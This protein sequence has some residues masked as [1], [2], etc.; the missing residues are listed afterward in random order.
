[1]PLNHRRTPSSQ[2]LQSE[3]RKSPDLAA[4]RLSFSWLELHRALSA[5]QY[6]QIAN[7][8]AADPRTLRC[9]KILLD[10]N[11]PA[12]RAVC[13]LR[14]RMVGYWKGITLPVAGLSDVRLLQQADVDTFIVQLA[15]LH[16]ELDDALSYLQACYEELQ[17]QA[18]TQLGDFYQPS[19]YPQSL[20]ALFGVSWDWP[21]MPLPGFHQHAPQGSIG[22]QPVPPAAQDDDEISW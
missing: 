13:A 1:M 16:A 21:R 6:L 19:D 8:F 22:D 15:S 2:S 14:R 20:S 18:K 9:S 17:K 10:P 7:A 12:L 4:V 11:H 3:A 5:D